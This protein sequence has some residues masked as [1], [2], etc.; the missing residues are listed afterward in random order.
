MK[1]LL[2]VPLCQVLA[3]VSFLPAGVAVQTAWYDTI[4]AQVS[5]ASDFKASRTTLLNQPPAL[6]GKVT[7]GNTRNEQGQVVQT[8]NPVSAVFSIIEGLVLVFYGYKSFRAFLFIIG[9]VLFGTVTLQILAMIHMNLGGAT[10]AVSYIIAAVFGV[11]GGL[12]L[13]ASYKLGIIVIGALFGVAVSM[14]ILYP[15]RGSMPNGAVIFVMVLLGMLGGYL[16]FKWERYALMVATASL[17]SLIFLCGVDY[18][19]QTRFAVDII[20]LPKV[21]EDGISGPLVLLMVIL[22]VA[23]AG[24]GVYVQIKEEKYTRKRKQDVKDAKENDKV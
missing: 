21:S 24:L 4:K 2:L 7:N 16:L 22:M 23:I 10:L 9:F 3:S 17:G 11:I 6:L 19:A 13:R 18:W 1:V 12:A 14:L 5:T 15:I 8:S 20:H